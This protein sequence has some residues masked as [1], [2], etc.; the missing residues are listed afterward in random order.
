M[1]EL[2]RLTLSELRKLSEY[3]FLPRQ[4]KKS[5]LKVAELRQ[6]IYNYRIHANKFICKNKYDLSKD[7]LIDTM[8]ETLVDYYKHGPRSSKK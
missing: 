5:T 8:R 2:N 6:S 7:E 1:E 3:S 4:S